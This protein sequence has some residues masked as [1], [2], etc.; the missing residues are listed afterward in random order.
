LGIHY[1]ENIKYGKYEND[2]LITTIETLKKETLD[3]Y[4]KN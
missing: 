2:D 4:C 3:Y 1:I